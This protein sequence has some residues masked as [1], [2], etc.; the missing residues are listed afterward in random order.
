MNFRAAADSTR[1]RVKVNTHNEAH[2][3]PID[4]IDDYWNAR[5]LS[6]GEAA[7]RILGFHVAKKTPA[8]SALPIHLPGSTSNRQYARKAGLAPTLSQLER[9]FLR[10]SGTFTDGPLETDR[11]FSALTYAEYYSLFRLVKYN[12]AND[13]K[14]HYFLEQPNATGAPRMHAILR[15][16]AHIHLSR[17]QSVRPSQGELFYLRAILQHKACLSFRDALTVGNTEYTTFQDVAIQLG[18]F[19]DSNEATYAMLEAVQTLRTPR[20]LRLLFVHLLVNDCVDS[21]IAMWDTF[22][23]ELSWDFILRANNI[24]H[25]GLNSAL[26]DISHLLEEYGKRLSDF[27]LPEPIVHSREVEH[28]LMRWGQ[29]PDVLAQRADQ[30]VSILKPEQ[31]EIYEHALASIMNGEPLCLFVD[32]KAGR[33]KTMLINTLCDKV[34]SLGRIVLPTATAAFAAQLYPGGRTT[35]SAFKVLIKI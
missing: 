24:T 28:E 35:H 1:Y 27:G 6:A 18:L 13:L 5:Y 10:P 11:S 4:E 21:P 26:D 23:V 9:Y 12:E 22:Q 20:Q 7:W 25:M 2:P 29:N 19:A 16:K 17:I 3:E 31:L 14:P 30:A 15:N 8:V 34:R 33:G 32:G